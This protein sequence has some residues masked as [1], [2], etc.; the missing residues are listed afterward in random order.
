ML[1]AR[2]DVDSFIKFIIPSI[3]VE[4]PEGKR[5]FTRSMRRW[6]GTG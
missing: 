4:N 3:L 1:L 5:S 2:A 6:E